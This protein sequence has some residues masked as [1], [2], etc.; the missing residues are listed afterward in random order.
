MS[1]SIHQW[2]PTVGLAVGG[3]TA[4]TE[5]P[6]LW[7][8]P[9]GAHGQRLHQTQPP[10][11]V[12][13]GLPTV[14]KTITVRH[15]I[16]GK[17]A[18]PAEP[19]TE[20]RAT[21]GRR[22]DAQPST[23]EPRRQGHWGG[24]LSFGSQPKSPSCGDW[25]C[26]WASGRLRNTPAGM[27]WRSAGPSQ[28]GGNRLPKQHGARIGAQTVKMSMCQPRSPRSPRSDRHRRPFG[29]SHAQGRRV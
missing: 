10:S 6:G 28:A 26:R 3:Y 4:G 5:S 13:N 11:H 23:A 18:R 21:S 9:H 14:T 20:L 17:V 27:P 24:A 7:T 1:S 22:E 2:A 25:E 8:L 29:D 19:R 12:P 15:A 16:L